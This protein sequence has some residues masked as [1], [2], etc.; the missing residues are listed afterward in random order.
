MWSGQEYEMEWHDIKEGSDLEFSEIEQV[1]GFLF[2]DNENICLVRPTIERGWRLPGGKPELEDKSWRETII[3]ES[4]EEA[5]LELEK[6]SLVLI[7]YFKVFPISENCTKKIHYVLRVVGKIKKVNKQT[8]DISEG[9]IN[10]RVFISIKD[11]LKY[12]PW[13]ESGK[14]QR[15]K[16]IEIWKRK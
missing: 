3:R 12:C 7:G 4:E 10:E 9:F 14:I 11:F 16:A 13:G 6:G 8:E 1:Y 15:D 2:D 5:D